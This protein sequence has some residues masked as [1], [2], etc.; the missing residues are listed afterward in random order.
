MTLPA[1]CFSIVIAVRMAKKN[2]ALPVI[3]I[4]AF[5]AGWAGKRLSPAPGEA[6]SSRSGNAPRR[7]VSLAPSVTETLF[8]LGLGDRVV[9]VT[10]FCSYPPEVRA[11]P[12]VGGYF[13]PSYEAIMALRPDLVVI[14]RE[15]EEPRKFLDGLG[16]RTLTVNH[17]NV[18]GIL[19]SITAIGIAAGVPE[20]ARAL[21][22]ELRAS[23]S[24]VQRRT[25]TLARPRVMV[26]VGRD[27][28]TGSLK[29][30]FISGSDGFENDLIA[31][32]GGVNVA[33]GKTIAYP[34]VGAETILDLNPDVIIEIA[35]N[36]AKAGLTPEGVIEE[37]NAAPQVAAVM[38]H[39]VYVLDRDYDGLPGP[40]F[41]LALLDFTRAIHPELDW[42]NP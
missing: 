25:A 6:A 7:I 38:N 40:R 11:K 26:S 28:G 37:W 18:A 36:L 31:L 27:L 9:G 13:D 22:A 21:D 14:L 19:A 3:I 17:K 24:R 33:T 35:P 41:P 30:V 34:T 23:V 8:A 4:L 15:H 10:R 29:D 42:E 32:A 20:S 39:R 1:R 12:R 16:I 5:A 2:L